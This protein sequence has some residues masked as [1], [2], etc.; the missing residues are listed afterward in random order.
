MKRRTWITGNLA[1]TLTGAAAGD[2][3]RNGPAS[4][5]FATAFDAASDVLQASVRRGDVEAASI[6]LRH[7]DQADGRG[8]G[9]APSADAIFLIASIT[10]PISVA[11]VIHLVERERLR[12]DDP[13]RKFIAE[14]K[15]DRRDEVTV[16]HLLTHTSGLPDQLPDNASLRQR[17]APL[18]EFIQGAIRTPLRFAPGTRYRY[19]S[20]GILLASDLATRVSGTPF[21][22]LVAE[23]VFRPLEMT[24]STLG[25]SPFSI[26][27]VMRCQVEN[28]APESGAGSAA[29]EDWDWNSLYWRQLASP[30]GGGHASAADIGRFLDA[31]LRPPDGWLRPE[32]VRLMT[33]NRNPPGVTPRG[34]GFGLGPAVASPGCSDQTFGHGG[35][36]GTLA[37]AD[38]DSDTTCVVLTTL[39]GRAADPHPR[40]L[41]SNRVAATMGRVEDSK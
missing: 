16:G 15:G 40:Q 39:P 23:T 28:A 14:F 31:C 7:G 27:Q 18:D 41:A 21:D 4:G 5:K 34:L 26:D 3:S 11:A 22:E 38:P 6:W 19:S 33:S 35:A 1:M 10:K 29:S 13:L 20:M 17:H 36:T 30:W 8:F 9:A 25:L 37:W 2:E 32:T 24:R 12:L